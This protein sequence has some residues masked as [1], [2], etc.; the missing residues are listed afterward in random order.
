MT[1]PSGHAPGQP[2]LA[3][4]WT[5][6]DKDLVGTA[7]GSSRLWYTLG[8]GI[9]NE[10]YS[11]RIDIPQ[12]RDLGFIV[13]DGAGFWV[14]VKRQ[15]DYTLS[16]P[17]P[18]VPLPT[19]VHR[20]PRFTLTLRLCPD[21]NREVLRLEVELEGDPALRPYLLLAP[22]L[23]GTGW[24]NQAWAG[25]HRGR[26]MLSARQ[27]S[28][29]LALLGVDADFHD[30]LGALSA[31]HVG[32]S[33]GW[34]DFARH[35]C[36][37]WNWG[38]AGP[39]NVAL[40]AELPPRTS[41]AL[42][43]ATSPQAAATLALSSLA[44]PFAVV[45]EQQRI[46]WTD[47]HAA[48]EAR[49]L[50]FDLPVALGEQLRSSA[51]VLKTHY[52]KTFHGAMVASLSVPWGNQG[53]ERGG[54][55]L[56]WPR[57]LV[58]CAQAL[59]ALGGEVEARAVLGYLMA[60]QNLD[61]HWYQN[62]WLGGR[63][64]WSGMQLD[65]T[66]FPVLLAVSLAERDA[67]GGM[68]VAD[69]TRRALAFL[70]R[71]GPSSPQDRWEEDAGVNPYTLA[72]CI[73]ALVAGAE[74]L[75]E[76]ERELPL[77]LADFWN[78]RLE[79]WCVARDTELDRA[80]GIAAHYVREAPKE[81][82]ACPT[83]L[84]RHLAIKN[85][86]DDPCLDA[87]AQVGVDFLQLVRLGLRRADDPLILDSLKL[88]DALL[89]TDTPS[90]PVWHRY[91]GDGYGEHAD[92][93][94]FDGTG[95]GRGWPLLVGERGHHALARGED[96]LPYLVAMNAMASTGGLLPEQVWDAAPLPKCGLL[97]GRP[98]GSAMPLAWA[99]AE[100]VKLAAS[101]AL[102]RVFDHPAAVWQRYAGSRADAATWVWTP[103][104][105][106]AHV[107]AGRDLLILL[108][109]PAVL[110]V[111][112]DG[113]EESLDLPTLPLGLELHGRRLAATQLDGRRMLDFTWQWREGTWLGE[114]FHLDLT[115]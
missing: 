70:I 37:R 29:A 73:A 18:G 36:M 77:L 47:W 74:L 53:D 90:G 93:T 31:G 32:E 89:K 67:L 71:E 112:F 61:G 25:M 106:I 87:A 88:V 66:A 82:L 35:G 8:H 16:T 54:Y 48:R 27:G 72:V 38:E 80:H 114:D 22:H 107:A 21:P 51:Q 45:W 23:G 5:S 41:L 30:A 43:L 63:P 52:D 55:H 3:P 1:A 56:V 111:G 49:C 64:Y 83:A 59:L 95:Q 28:F 34:Q 6:S 12:I 20:H 79:D 40:I 115:N 15:A 97:P 39:G 69:M 68:P 103:G 99:H 58:E 9:V 110:H 2:G 57:D 42:G 102:G 50:S 113:W 92:G 46:A 108:P 94:P 84:R 7:I 10:V 101:H 81:I 65:E 104:A 17:T 105:Q 91:T 14:E 109:R 62:Q 26:R 24:H 44:E 86:T 13:A 85:R 98:T 100:F 75:P 76:A 96:P 4:T 19:I 11:P 78:A 33:D 60:T